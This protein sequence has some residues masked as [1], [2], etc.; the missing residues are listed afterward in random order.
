[1][2][3]SVLVGVLNDV[4]EVVHLLLGQLA[5]T[6][7]HVYVCLLAG[8]VGETATHTLHGAHDVHNL[9]PV[10]HVGTEDTQ[11]VL[12]IATILDDECL[13]NLEETYAICQRLREGK[14]TR[15]IDGKANESAFE[16]PI[17]LAV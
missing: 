14:I 3:P 4:D 1:M 9:L 11:D 6:L 13:V 16:R 15:D 2:C 8:D 10:I 7:V 5:R 17:Y 12:E